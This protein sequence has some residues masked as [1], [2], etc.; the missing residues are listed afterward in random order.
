MHCVRAVADSVAMHGPGSEWIPSAL[1]AVMAVPR[2]VPWLL[3]ESILALGAYAEWFKD[4]PE[5]IAEAMRFIVPAMST[6]GHAATAAAYAF[7]DFCGMRNTVAG[8]MA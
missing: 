3:Y 6:T 4:Q 8:A 5:A 2:D 1:Q 7:Y